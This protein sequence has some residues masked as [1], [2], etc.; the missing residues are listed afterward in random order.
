MTHFPGFR[1]LHERIPATI[2]AG[3]SGAA[4]AFEPRIIKQAIPDLAPLRLG[5]VDR[6]PAALFNRD[7]ARPTV[8]CVRKEN[9]ADPQVLRLLQIQVLHATVLDRRDFLNVGTINNG[10][11]DPQWLTQRDAGALHLLNY[12]LIPT[13]RPPKAL[14]FR[15]FLP[16]LRRRAV[17]HHLIAGT[18]ALG[19]LQVQDQVSAAAVLSQLQLWSLQ[20]SPR[21]GDGAPRL[22][23]WPCIVIFR[24]EHDPDLRGDCL[25][26][27]VIRHA[28][29]P[30]RP[31]SHLPKRVPRRNRIRKC[32]AGVLSTAPSPN[33][34]IANEDLHGLQP[35]GFCMQLQP[36]VPPNPAPVS[37]PEKPNSFLRQGVSEDQPGPSRALAANHHAVAP[38]CDGP[39]QVIGAFSQ[40][41]GAAAGLPRSFAGS[42]QRL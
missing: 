39:V 37:R 38:D 13:I 21:K 28:P 23:H 17:N 15:Q 7:T 33:L 5:A 22:L 25:A 32:V 36:R 18:Q 8:P 24:I 34:H 20:T 29:K 14:V 6:E 27:T 11:F 35:R 30:P 19:A 3:V 31:I 1:I 9:A 12:R 16:S 40:Q 42:L 10:E 26:V 41:H 2:P 4:T